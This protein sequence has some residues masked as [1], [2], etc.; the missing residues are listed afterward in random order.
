LAKKQKKSRKVG[1]RGRRGVFRLA[2]T[3]SLASGKSTALKTLG[4]L[5]WKTASAD[6]MVAE[7]YRDKG[8]TKKSLRL[9]FGTTKAGLK[10]L[11]EMVH[12]L[13]E[14]RTLKF[15]KNSKGP[16]AVEVP[17]LFE[18]KFDRHFDGCLFIHSPLA[19]RRRRALKRGMSPE[20]FDF[21]NAQQF[22]DEK[23]ARLADFVLPND[24]KKILRH[25]LK[26]LSG[27]LLDADL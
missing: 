9:K 2:I 13:V 25:E 1:K 3:G 19:A 26:V 5:G 14:K 8:L 23:K 4:K 27:I 18:A 21:L 11:M 24:S 10:R 22:S 15:L 7:I 20:L 17:L 6:Q 16:C 12:P